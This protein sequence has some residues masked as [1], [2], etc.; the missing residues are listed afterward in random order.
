M[1]DCHWRLSP[2]VR[3]LLVGLFKRLSLKQLFWSYAS[4]MRVLRDSVCTHDGMYAY[5]I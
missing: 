4:L 3:L 2:E 1:V 5:K